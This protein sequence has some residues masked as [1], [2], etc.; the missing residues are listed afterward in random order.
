MPDE[1]GE[2][3]AWVSLARDLGIALFLIV[4]TFQ[5]FAQAD[6]RRPEFSA[7]DIRVITGQ[8]AEFTTVRVPETAAAPQINSSTIRAR[9]AFRLAGYP[10]NIFAYIPGSPWNM[11]GDIPLG[12]EVRLEAT[13]DPEALTARARA[14]PDAAFLLPI[15]GLQ[16][17]E[18]VHFRASDAIARAEDA[19]HRYQR[20]GIAAAFISTAWLGW[21]AWSRRRA[22]HAIARAVREH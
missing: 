18:H 14:N 12:T 9:P 17:G 22:L 1:R 3:R 5:L 6:R 7:D 11:E 21:L 4:V 13:E 20:L 16:I 8:I 15:A 10:P 19:A 2:S